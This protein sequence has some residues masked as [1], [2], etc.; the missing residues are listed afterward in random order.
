[1]AGKEHPP[2]AAKCAWILLIASTFLFSQLAWQDLSAVSL[3]YRIH[4]SVVHSNPSLLQQAGGAEEKQHSRPPVKLPPRPSITVEEAYE[5]LTQHVDPASMPLLPQEKALRT[6]FLPNRNYMSYPALEMEQVCMNS[7]GGLVLINIT[8]EEIQQS[9]KTIP[10]LSHLWTALYAECGNQTNMKC[11]GFVLEPHAPPHSK[12]AHGSTLHFI[13]FSGYVGPNPMHQFTERVWQHLA[14][15]FLPNLDGEGLVDKPPI[16]RFVVHWF[17]K[18]M[19]QAKHPRT[20]EMLWQA[21]MLIEAIAPNASLLVLDE[22]AGHNHNSGLLS[23]IHDQL[24]TM[25][26]FERLLLQAH[27]KDRMDITMLPSK[28]YSRALQHFRTSVFSFFNMSLPKVNRSPSPLRTLI[29]LRN[30]TH[31][32]RVV[33]AN[34]VLAFMRNNISQPKLQ[35]LSLDEMF[36]RGEATYDFPTI[37]YLMSQSDVFVVAHG[38]NTWNAIFLPENSLIIEIFGPCNWFHS[39]YTDI[40]VLHTWIHPIAQAVHLKHDLSNPFKDSIP[41]PSR[42]NTT[43]CIEPISHVPDYTIDVFKFRKIFQSLCSPS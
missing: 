25:V 1:M 22:Q 19:G 12:W 20:A 18:W 43:K 26:C 40:R 6:R 37:I 28:L 14:G 7:R 39:N 4:S 23:G 15:R 30:D 35:I 33:N 41:N 38:A 17:R 5:R 13:P 3:R 29:Y 42:G 36:A 9:M 16:E 10:S 24:S 8:H 34:E 27:D 2:R 32:R 21:R 31:R 11:A